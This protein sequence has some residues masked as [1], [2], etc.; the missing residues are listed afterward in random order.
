MT[1]SKAKN[2]RLVWSTASLAGAIA[3]VAT[4]HANS[5]VAHKVTPA[6]AAA[7]QQEKKPVKLRYY[8]GP[9]YPMYPQ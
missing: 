9:K 5:D 1:I 3:L 8:G 6:K 4:T 2:L 7:F